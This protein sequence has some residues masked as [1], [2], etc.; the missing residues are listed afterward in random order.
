MSSAMSLIPAGAIPPQAAAV[1]PS[2]G[3]PPIMS[4]LWQVM[5][6]WILGAP[7]NGSAAWAWTVAILYCLFLVFYMY[8]FLIARLQKGV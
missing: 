6:T 2:N 1:I 4:A 7:G 5:M 3:F 8:F